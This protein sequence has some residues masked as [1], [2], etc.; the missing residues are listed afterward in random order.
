VP[1]LILVQ[2]QGWW[3]LAVPTQQQPVASE[4]AQA[5]RLQH[6]QT[7]NIPATMS[8]L[9]AR[10]CTQMSAA[11]TRPS[12]PASRAV[13]GPTLCSQPRRQRG[14]QHHTVQCSMCRQNKAVS[15]CRNL[16]GMTAM[17]CGY[18]LLLHTHQHI[19]AAKQSGIAL[20]PHSLR[21]QP[22]MSLCMHGAA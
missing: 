11:Q 4:G 10:P 9:L 17:K 3:C 18:Q 6:R 8:S 15:F 19:L 5:A 14:G 16:S 21:T 12:C 7:R 22:G 13:T 20:S 1:G 2:Q